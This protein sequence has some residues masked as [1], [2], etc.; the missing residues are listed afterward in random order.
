ML[1]R[2]CV[3]AVIVSPEGQVFAGMRTDRDGVWQ[4]PQGGVDTGESPKEAVIRELQE[5]IGCS[6]VIIR[7]ISSEKITYDFPSDLDVP[8][9]KKFRGQT[10]TWFL[11][12]FGRGANP[13]L[14]NSDHEFQALAW[15]S[16]QDLIEGAVDWKRAAYIEGFKSL[17][18]VGD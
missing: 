13:S 5:E 17:G 14:E 8:I 2:E 18:L 11:M 10:Q 1:Y 16:I 9:A 4:L 6:D 7:E 3:V 12:E 15:K